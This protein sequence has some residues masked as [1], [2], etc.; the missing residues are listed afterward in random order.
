MLA[1]SEAV[2]EGVDMIEFDVQLSKDRQV[3]VIHDS[4]LL[5]TT[6]TPGQVYDKTLDE[7]KRLDAGSF[8]SSEFTGEEIPELNELSW[9][10]LGCSWLNLEMK[11]EA[12]QYVDAGFLEN[13]VIHFLKS[14]SLLKR[15]IISSFYHPSLQ[16]IR[17]LCPEALIGV[18]TDKETFNMVDLLA[19]SDAVNAY[20]I[21]CDMECLSDAFI[22]NAHKRGKKIFVYTVD[23]PEEMRLL[24]NKGIDGIFTNKPDVF[25]ETFDAD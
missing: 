23:D 24:R 11:E 20:S 1:F 4:D 7:L 15:T 16:N 21:H 18:L 12:F 14:H 17:R 3:V 13:T 10:P 22:N 25:N 19:I 9:L 5:R 8:L 6:N 2:R